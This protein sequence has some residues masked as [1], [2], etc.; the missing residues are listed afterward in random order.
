MT[1]DL[2]PELLDLLTNDLCDMAIDLREMGRVDRLPVCQPAWARPERRDVSAR[3]RTRY[4][5]ALLR[6][7]VWGELSAN[8]IREHI[9]GITIGNGMH[10]G[11]G[12]VKI[13]SLT[14]VTEVRGKRKAKRSKR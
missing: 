2:T 8:D 14:S 13:R 12:S 7:E 6:V 5:K 11:G 4:V 10:G 9:R 3:V 1:L